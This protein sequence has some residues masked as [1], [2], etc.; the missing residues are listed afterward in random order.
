MNRQA[1]PWVPTVDGDFL[2]DSP[3]NLLRRGRFDG[4]KKQALL[5]ANADEGT[6]WIL[7]ALPGFSRHGPS[8]HTEEMYRAGVDKIVWD[9]D[10]EQVS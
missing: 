10:A 6:F 2:T 3:R 4:G 9:L 5:G 8:R 1:F 7:F